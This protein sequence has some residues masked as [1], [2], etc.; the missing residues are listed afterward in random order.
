[1]ILY[2]SDS[3]HKGISFS[4]SLVLYMCEVSVRGAG[5][6]SAARASNRAVRNRSSTARWV[7]K[8][9]SKCN[10][11][12]MSKDSPARSIRNDSTGESE[13]TEDL[14][15]ASGVQGCY[16]RVATKSKEEAADSGRAPA[17]RT[18]TF[19]SPRHVLKEG[20]ATGSRPLL[21]RHPSKCLPKPG[22]GSSVVGASARVPS[23]HRAIASLPIADTSLTAA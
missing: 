12:D 15:S 2:F 14:Q 10:D 1:M 13:A 19:Q 11:K 7:P 20:A 3:V 9:V 8:A 17:A 23:R 5:S 18:D 22:D 6:I 4:G 21:A 16:V